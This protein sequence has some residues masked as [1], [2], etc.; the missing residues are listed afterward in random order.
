MEASLTLSVL[1]FLLLVY[2]P[3]NQVLIAAGRKQEERTLAACTFY[4]SAILTVWIVLFWLLGWVGKTNVLE[5]FT[6]SLFAAA[7]GKGDF[8]LAS[9]GI[10]FACSYVTATLF[11]LIEL[12]LLTG[13]CTPPGWLR[14]FLNWFY[15]R[16]PVQA[17]A[18]ACSWLRVRVTGSPSGVRIKPRNLLLEILI[19]FRRAGKRPHLEI[20]LKDGTRHEGECLRYSWNE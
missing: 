1:L 15:A 2:V 6:N 17:V 18:R 3:G 5:R 11:G 8:D 10:F 19:R 12:F 4:R 14:R 7:S 13:L 16:R 9:V 20:T